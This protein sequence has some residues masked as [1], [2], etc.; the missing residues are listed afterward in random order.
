ME[1]RKV[2]RTGGST[3]IVSLPKKWVD[4]NGIQPGDALDVDA[5]AGGPVTIYPV[6]TRPT[7][8]RN[9]ALTINP[10]SPKSHIERQVI[11]AYLAGYETLTVQAE[12]RF[13]AEHKQAIRNLAQTLIGIEIVEETQR[14]ITLQDLLDPVDFDLT[15]AVERMHQL[16]RVMVADAL[17]CLR[18][19]ETDLAEDIP[20][21]DPEVD[22][23]D[24]M[25]VKQFHLISASG[26]LASQLDLGP[27]HALHHLLVSHALERIADHAARLA[28]ILQDKGAQSLPQAT[29]DLVADYGDRILTLLDDAFRAFRKSDL[30]SANDTLTTCRDVATTASELLA[31]G[32]GQTAAAQVALALLV[33]SIERVRSY[34]M[35]IAE[36]AIDHHMLR[37][38]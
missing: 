15:K 26:R 9:L 20:R 37:P 18:T 5:E 21:R 19:S 25:I 16:A 31:R 28:E 38:R 14:S 33:K 29:R 8:A 11:G 3:F 36:A 12:G 27:S 22:R 35:D 1:R 32:K 23:L 7:T 30:A 13:P 10:A 24:W 4:A 6:G 2:Q 17:S 34:T